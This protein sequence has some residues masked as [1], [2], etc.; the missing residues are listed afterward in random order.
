MGWS[1]KPGG[2]GQSCAPGSGQGDWVG[3]HGALTALGALTNS[4]R[5][6]LFSQ[7]CSGGK[8]WAS[9]PGKRTH[10]FQS[11]CE[12]A[13]FPVWLRLETWMQKRAIFDSEN[14]NFKKIY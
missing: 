4:C 3:A 6:L 2:P 13:S 5:L 12:I 10:G 8:V 11:W 7:F 9:V 1:A 14:K